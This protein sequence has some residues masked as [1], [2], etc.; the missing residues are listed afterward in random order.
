MVIS[1]EV[2]SKTPIIERLILTFKVEENKRKM[3]KKSVRLS[4]N[5]LILRICT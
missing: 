3:M 5:Y 1:L 4:K 2:L